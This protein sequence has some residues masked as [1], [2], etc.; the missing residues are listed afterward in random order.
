MVAIHVQADAMTKSPSLVRPLP[1]SPTGSPCVIIYNVGYTGMNQPH[2]NIICILTNLSN[3]RDLI[4]I[5]VTDGM[6]NICATGQI[7]KQEGRMYTDGHELSDM[8]DLERDISSIPAV[9]LRFRAIPAC[10]KHQFESL[11]SQLKRFGMDRILITLLA[12]LYASNHMHCTIDNSWAN[13]AH[14][15]WPLGRYWW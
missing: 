3:H 13:S 14:Y 9:L 8:F 11:M 5:I 12:A 2:T 1:E 4:G 10:D 7:G 15:W 6:I